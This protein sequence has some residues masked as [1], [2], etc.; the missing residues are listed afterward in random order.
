MCDAQTRGTVDS[1]PRS[2]AFQDGR[3]SQPTEMDLAQ[4][5]F[6]SQQP[7]GRFLQTGFKRQS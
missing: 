3:F 2:N 4:N 5:T 6:Y 1:F 7:P